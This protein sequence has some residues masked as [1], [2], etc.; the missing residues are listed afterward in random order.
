MTLDML[1]A[2][3]TPPVFTMAQACP[4]STLAAE[5]TPIVPG[6]VDTPTTVTGS[7]RGAN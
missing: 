4:P 1:L 3:L 5:T 7:N 6:V 2:A